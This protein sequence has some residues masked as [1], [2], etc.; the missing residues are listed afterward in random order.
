MEYFSKDLGDIAM[1]YV[2]T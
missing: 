2:W 1:W